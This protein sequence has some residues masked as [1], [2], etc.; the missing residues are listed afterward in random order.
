MSEGKYKPATQWHPLFAELLRP[1]LQDYY[2]VQTNVP[3]GDVPREADILLLRRTSEQPTPFLGLWR[4]L[5]AWNVLEFKGPTVDARVQDVHLLVEVGLGIYRR[6][7]EERRRQRQKSLEPEQASFWYVVRSLGKRLQSAL[8]RRVAQ[9]EEIE[10]GLWRGQILQHMIFLVSSETFTSQ[11]DSVPL[12][13]LVKR[14]PEHERELAHLVVEQPHFL[15]W[16]GTM[17]G[18]LHAE[19]WMEVREMATTK[20]KGLDFD[21]SVIKDDMTP[22]NDAQLVRTIGVERILKAIDPREIIREMGVDWLLANLSPA[23]LRK[24]KDRLK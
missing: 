17:L 16:Y 21:F 23:E 9:V 13:L 5:T 4:H 18:A 14:S 6:L 24:L 22:E 15:E 1:L 20:R 2:D 8:R 11:P 3:V 19:A 7:N 12:H 10:T